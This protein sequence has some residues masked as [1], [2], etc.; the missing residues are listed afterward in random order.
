MKERKRTATIRPS[1]FVSLA[2]AIVF[3]LFL[4]FGVTLVSVGIMEN[5]SETGLQ[6]LIGIFG[7]IWVTVCSFG[8]A[9]NIRNY[10]SWSKDPPDKTVAATIGVIEYDA[11]E[12][13]GN[14]VDFDTKLRKLE[15]LKK[16]G[17]ITEEEYKRKHKEIMDEKW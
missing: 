4:V 5:R 8:I 9:F 16:D 17:L 2:G 10:R 6:V 11:A 1:P 12:N 14:P 7:L 3:A 15:S 13:K